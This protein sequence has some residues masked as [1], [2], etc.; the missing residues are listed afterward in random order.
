MKLWVEMIGF[1]FLFLTLTLNSTVLGFFV[2]VVYFS[3]YSL[4]VTPGQ[5]L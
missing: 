3:S 4:S 1:C 2:V 5:W